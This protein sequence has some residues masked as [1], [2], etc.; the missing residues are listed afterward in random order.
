VTGNA[1]PC[2]GAQVRADLEVVEKKLSALLDKKGNKRKREDGK[3]PG[4][5]FAPR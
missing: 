4:R 3:P 2:V 1:C 5:L